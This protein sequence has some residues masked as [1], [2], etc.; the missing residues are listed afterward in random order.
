MTIFSR[1]CRALPLIAGLILLV[2]ACSQQE[3]VE[4]AEPEIVATVNGEPISDE[5]LNIEGELVR[6]EQEAYK[7]RQEAIDRTVGMK[8]L[9]KEA[10]ENGVSVS[11]LLEEFV[12]SHVA[13]VTPEE[14][15]RFYAQNKSRIRKPLEEVR[16][17]LTAAI[18]QS[19]VK[20]ARDDY[21]AQLR[22]SA[23]VNVLIEPPRLPVDL[24]NAHRRGPADAPVTLVEFSDFQCPF[25][26][27]V[28]PTLR[29]VFD[30]YEGKM[31]WVFK[32]LPLTQIH[33]AA[34]RA[35]EAA[36]CAG[37]Q[38]K[39][40]EYRDGLFQAKRVSDEIHPEMVKEL[41]LDAEA[42]EACL[43][44]GKHRAVV[45]AARSEAQSL[46]ISGTPAFIIN[47]ILLSGAQPKEEFVKIIEAELARTDN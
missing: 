21:V 34:Q 18:K 46:G 17:D 20:Q 40:W 30:E 8:L 14:V 26:K 1:S 37:D 2:L 10:N 31:N 47:G 3:P 33:P 19:R 22:K 45:Q 7:I 13:D 16:D 5:D 12:D 38:G 29:Q 28:Q 25:C 39:F 11:E 32:D 4:A 9:E 6:L 43:D 41:G 15:E 42:F 35:A 27:R 23:D 24:E 44:S 36:R